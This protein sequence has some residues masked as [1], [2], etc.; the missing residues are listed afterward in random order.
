MTT[1]IAG[2]PAREAVRRE[3][4]T[5]AY[6]LLRIV[7]IVAPILFG[8][9]KFANVLTD[10]WTK[11]LAT[12]FNDILP[13]S[14]A[15][16]MHIVGVVEI[17]AG[18]LVLLAPR[19]G[20]LIVAGWLA[21]II[22]NL[23]ILGGYGDIALRDF[24]LLVGALALNRLATPERECS[25]PPRWSETGSRTSRPPATAASRLAR[26]STRCSSRRR[27]SR[28]GA[29]ACRMTI[30]PPRRPATP[31]SRSWASSTATAARAA[32]RRGPT[33]SRSTRR[34]RRP[35]SAPGRNVRCCSAPSSGRRSP[36]PRTTATRPSC[37]ARSRAGSSS[38]SR[39]TSARCCSRS[40]STA[41]R[42]T[43]SPS[44]W[45]RPAAR[46]TRPCT[47]LAATCAHTW[48]KHEPRPPT[49]RPARPRPPGADLRGVLRRARH[50]GR[51]RPEGQ[52]DRPPHAG[53]PRR[54]PG[55]PGGLRKLDGLPQRLR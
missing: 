38:A 45:T 39:R 49:A 4:A 15:T 28:S 19:I 53:A 42:S 12:Q 24:G 5:Q 23:L 46:F 55:V 34:P 11:Y 1:M 50:P 52:A 41:C 32:S 17:A 21:G 33:S 47:T 48:S 7:F 36:P 6:V 44:A 40:R 14:A 29:G 35:A 3:P 2:F 25:P 30:S 9:D 16:G 31:C 18:L 26:S 10:D 8:I 51:G 13:G 54:L 20:S 37:C 27:R 22:L 43:S